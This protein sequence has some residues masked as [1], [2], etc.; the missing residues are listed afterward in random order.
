MRFV[1]VSVEF[2]FFFFKQK[3][4]YEILR[5]DWSS[6]VCSSDL[7]QLLLSLKDCNGKNENLQ[8]PQKARS[9][10]RSE[11][12]RVGKECVSTCRYRWSPAHLKKKNDSSWFGA[13]LLRSL[14]LYG[15]RRGVQRARS[16]C[17]CEQKT[18][19]E[20]RRSDWSS[21]VCSSDLPEFRGGVHADAEVIKM[22]KKT[23]PAELKIPTYFTDQEV[24]DLVVFLKALTS[25]SARNLED[26]VPESVPSGLEM[27]LPIP[28]EALPSD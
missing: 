27:V 26:T 7:M 14:E 25:P 16:V 18:A 15:R 11:E 19:Y 2:C 13:G 6:D 28:E 21:D 24:D 17:F 3:T 20:F 23:M 22:V 1:G 8:Q 4:A 9:L 5:S 10:F 12:R